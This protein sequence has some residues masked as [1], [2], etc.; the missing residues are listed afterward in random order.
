MVD[1]EG[2]F[3]ESNAIEDVYGDEPLEE[4]L[5]AWDYLKQH[6]ELKHHIIKET[7]RL[8]MRNRQPVLAGEYRDV[9]VYVGDHTP[10][11]PAVVRMKM[12]E[13]L[14]VEPENAEEAVK[15]HISF[16]TIH[17]FEDGNGRIGR[18]IYYWHCHQ[19]GV[20]PILW[21]ADERQKYYKI[22]NGRDGIL[23]SQE[24]SAE[25]DIE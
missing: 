22:F 18:M 16:E 20:E 6:D 15:W 10:P 17:P 9:Q 24:G 2:F 12:Q 7:H 11:D 5:E 4:S 8:I 1:K 25:V 23:E 21:T 19:L 13:L 3:R 14:Q